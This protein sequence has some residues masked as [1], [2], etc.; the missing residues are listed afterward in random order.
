FRR[1]VPTVPSGGTIVFVS[2]SAVSYHPDAEVREEGGTPDIVGSIRAGLAFARRALE[3]WGADPNIEILGD[4]RPDR[5]AILTLGLRHE[6]AL[7]HGN[8][9]VA[10][11]S[12]L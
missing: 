11:L 9:V 2:P 1:A 5:L 7:L 10:V 3:S 8:F 6:G 12:D 4:P